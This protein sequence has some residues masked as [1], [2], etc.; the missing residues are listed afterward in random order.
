MILPILEP[1][2]SQK[3]LRDLLASFFSRMS[4]TSL[5]PARAM[6]AMSEV[7]SR[8]RHDRLSLQ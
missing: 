2:I 6:T 4:R 8:Q 1:A 7:G 3:R 5:D